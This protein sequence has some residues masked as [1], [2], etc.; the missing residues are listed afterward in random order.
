MNL[1]ALVALR[2]AAI[3]APLVLGAACSGTSEQR[4]A[5]AR[6]QAGPPRVVTAPVESSPFSTRI[7]GVGT[8]SAQDSIE[9]VVEATQ[10]IASIHFVEGQKVSKGALLVAMDSSEARAT[11]AAAEAMLEMSRLQ[12][13]RSQGL[14]AAEAL[15][16]AQLEQI[17]ANYK[18]RAAQADLARIRL[19]QMTLRAPFAGRTGLRKASVGALVAA[20][21]PITTLDDT[22][23]MRIDFDVPQAI[24]GRIRAGERVRAYAHGLGDRAFAG[25]VA[26]IDPRLDSASRSA[27]VRAIV[28]NEHDELRP[29]MYVTVV[30][31][32]DTTS[33]R[34]VPEQALVTEGDK[35]FAYVLRGDVVSR[36]SVTIGRRRPGEVEI[37]D[38]L[39]PGERVVVEGLQRLSDGARVQDTTGGLQRPA[40]AAG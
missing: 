37:L 34:V 27:R 23:S 7:E 6:S 10:R 18:E 28:P 29:G 9:I 33:S 35:R 16:A 5:G 3:V 30:I 1:R 31:E 38:G 20:G 39:Q 2:V 14:R 15:S 32:V 24:V 21:S 8:A 26:A 13:Q 36:R 12:L 25:Q 11:L 40:R 17:E 4:T 22:R 19:R